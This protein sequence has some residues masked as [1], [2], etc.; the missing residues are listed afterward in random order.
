MV[1]QC[2]IR[3]FTVFVYQT[4]FIILR[5]FFEFEWCNKIVL[6]TSKEN[7]FRFKNDKY[8]MNSY[9][10]LW[11]THK[12]NISKVGKYLNF[13]YTIN[14]NNNQDLQCSSSLSPSQFS[15]FSNRFF[16]ITIY[17]YFL[18]FIFIKK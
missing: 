3:S 11:F 4:A 12:I 8:E 13:F 10:K 1:K 5:S 16:I 15:Y 9:W 7:Y 2:A 18:C 17:I 14:N 6:C